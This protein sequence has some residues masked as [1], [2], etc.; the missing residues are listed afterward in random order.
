M[1]ISSTCPALFPP[2]TAHFLSH[3]PHPDIH[4]FKKGFI[5]E[6]RFTSTMKNFYKKIVGAF[7]NSTNSRRGRCSKRREVEKTVSQ[8]IIAQSSSFI[9]THFLHLTLFG[10]LKRHEPHHHHHHRHLN[11]HHHRISILYSLPLFSAELN[12]FQSQVDGE[13]DYL[14]EIV[15]RR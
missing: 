7:A 15:H 1:I 10:F 2:T 9:Y 4:D 14:L 8:M 11:L 13:R 5:S 6:L 12:S 3:S